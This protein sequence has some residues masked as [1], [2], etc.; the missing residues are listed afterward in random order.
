MFYKLDDCVGSVLATSA[1][2]HLEFLRIGKTQQRLY[3]PQPWDASH[4]SAFNRVVMAMGL[5]TLT[6]MIQAQIS[7]IA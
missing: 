3:V 5:A 2:Q 7:L 4:T 6:F 1:Q